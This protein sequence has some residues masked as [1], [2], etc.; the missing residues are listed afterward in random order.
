MAA[1]AAEVAYW[2]VFRVLLV[3]ASGGRLAV[4]PS[5]AEKPRSSSTAAQTTSTVVLELR[6]CLASLGQTASLPTRSH[7]QEDPKGRPER[8]KLQDRAWEGRL[9]GYSQGQPGL[10]TAS[11]NS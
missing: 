2:A 11:S 5:E 4:C 1:E 8:R 9:V 3:M 6:V 7:S 10:H